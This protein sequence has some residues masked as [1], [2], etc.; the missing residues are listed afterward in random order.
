MPKR[1]HEEISP[2]EQP[3]KKQAKTTLFRM[4]YN[5]AKAT[6]YGNFQNYL[7]AGPNLQKFL[8]AENLPQQ[9]QEKK[10]INLLNLPPEI[11]GEIARNLDEQDIRNLALISRRFYTLVYDEEHLIRFNK[12]ISLQ[13][14]YTQVANSLLKEALYIRDNWEKTFNINNWKS[15]I[16][17]SPHIVP[18]AFKEGPL[19]NKPFNLGKINEI[20]RLLDECNERVIRSKINL[21]SDLLDLEALGLTRLPKNLFEDVSL[22]KYW[23]NLRVLNLE[24]NQLTALPAEIGNLHRLES[25][26]L[27][28]NQLTAL[29]P[30]IGNL[31][32]LSR[33]YLQKNRLTTLPSEI[34]NLQELFWLLLEMNELTALPL[35]IGAAQKLTI[36]SLEYNHL[37]R[38]DLMLCTKNPLAIDRILKSQTPP[39]Q[40]AA[41]MSSLYRP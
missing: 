3:V 35:E 15:I 9:E 27:K 10:S 12:N 17:R 25:L 19:L 20:N 22:N 34:G 38:E 37:R 40:E 26:F 23:K 18:Q 33:L 8:E 30:E 21:K 31:H 13:Q 16:K 1:R 4:I 24:N 5:A 6:I 41:K 28:N 2:E 36:I 11:I 32:K 7:N 39:P 14:H 29:P